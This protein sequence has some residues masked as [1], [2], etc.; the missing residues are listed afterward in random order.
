MCWLEPAPS[1]LFKSGH[2]GPVDRLA[3][4][5]T[6]ESSPQK[7]HQ[8]VVVNQPPRPVYLTPSDRRFWFDS[9]VPSRCRLKSQW[10]GA[11]VAGPGYAC[12]PLAPSAVAALPCRGRQRIV[13]GF[14]WGTVLTRTPSESCAGLGS[15]CLVR[16]GTSFLG[17]RCS[18]GQTAATTLNPACCCIWTGVTRT[19]LSE[20]SPCSDGVDARHTSGWARGIF[21]FR[22]IRCRRL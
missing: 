2:K 16:A 12:N 11:D 3:M 10:L 9:S 19:W 17:R 22:R 14:L 7:W 6:V 20:R 1:G 13:G 18:C 15:I 5:A 4:V 21:S 8:A